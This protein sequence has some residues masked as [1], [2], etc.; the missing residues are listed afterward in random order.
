[1]LRQNLPALAIAA[2][3]ATASTALAQTTVTTVRARAKRSAQSG[4][5]ERALADYAR[6]AFAGDR[7][8]RRELGKLHMQQVK[9]LISA[10]KGEATPGA[11]ELLQRAHA[12]DPFSGKLR[13]KL[14]SPF[15]KHDY[16]YAFGRYRAEAEAKQLEEQRRHA[17]DARRDELGLPTS[18]AGIQRGPFRFY[19]DVD[20]KYGKRVVGQ[21]LAAIEAHLVRYVEVM[22]PLGLTHASDLDVVLFN[23]EGDYLAHTKASGSAGVY[24]PSQGC[25]YFFAGT[26]GFDFPPLLHEKTHQLNDKLLKAGVASPWFEEG[27]AEYFGAGELKR[28]CQQ[29][30]VGR[31][32]RSRLST[33]RGMVTGYQ[34]SVTPLRSFLAARQAELSGSYY[35]QA[36]ALTQ[37]LMEGGLPQGRMIVYDLIKTAQASGQRQARLSDD[38]MREILGRYGWTIEALEKAYLAYHQQGCKPLRGMAAF[39]K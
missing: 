34:G 36:W 33:F 30:Q 1:M 27:I 39:L 25:G 10:A 12:L 9:D 31:P 26:A 29:L 5:V 17:L 19:T 7:G 38:T 11:V 13:R 35:A 16:T 23:K 18:F 14:R 4:E 8:A 24:I 28:G 37:F 32:E 6:L 20:P 21:M 22:G 2:L 15:A 3:L